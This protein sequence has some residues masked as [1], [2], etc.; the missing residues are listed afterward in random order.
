MRKK[1][2][3]KEKGKGKGRGKKKWKGIK[4]ESCV[5]I[6]VDTNNDKKEKKKFWNK[7]SIFFPIR[8]LESFTH[9]IILMSCILR[10]IYVTASLELY[11]IFQG[12]QTIVFH[13]A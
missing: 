12:K 13:L 8:V 5:Q 1:D 10:K 3:R 4:I 11:L 6:E 2:K 7:K 9:D